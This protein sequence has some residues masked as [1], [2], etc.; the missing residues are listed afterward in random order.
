MKKMMIVLLGAA[1]MLFAVPETFAGHHGHHKGNDG[2]RLAAGI[3]NLVEAAITPAPQV[4][5]APPAL[6]IAPPPPVIHH[7]PAPQKRRHEIR[8][9]A[10][11]P[12]PKRGGH[13]R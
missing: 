5:Y 6:A 4:I 3:V 2:L 10:P 7:R 12:Q 1:A 11:K 13:K 8:R 9:P